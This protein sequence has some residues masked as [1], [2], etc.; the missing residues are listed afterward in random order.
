MAA[1]ALAVIANPSSSTLQKTSAIAQAAAGSVTTPFTGN[2]NAPTTI[3]GKQVVGSTT[4]AGQPGFLVKD[5]QGNITSVP[6]QALYRHLEYRRSA[7]NV[8]NSYRQCP[9]VR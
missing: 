6:Q 2:I 9:N 5:A 1:N 7:S 3:A 4:V 8:R